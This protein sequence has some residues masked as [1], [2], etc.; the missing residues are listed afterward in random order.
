[1]I[2]SWVALRVLY[3]IH[4][5]LEDLQWLLSYL[6]L[7]SRQ[8]LCS[9][10]LQFDYLCLLLFKCR[11][12]YR[13]VETAL[14]IVLKSNKIITEVRNT[15]L[16]NV[17]AFFAHSRI[18]TW[19][20]HE[21]TKDF[22][23]L[24]CRHQLFQNHSTKQFAISCGWIDRVSSLKLLNV[25]KIIVLGSTAYHIISLC[26]DRDNLTTENI[27]PLKVFSLLQLQIRKHRYFLLS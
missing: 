7:R 27:I 12:R 4:W 26:S 13:L 19:V 22:T 9:R 18:C 16:V 20:V 23:V 1:M 5:L 2:R 24:N 8:S 17:S 11:I 21:V 10:P 15:R 6:F 3:S 25:D 14:A